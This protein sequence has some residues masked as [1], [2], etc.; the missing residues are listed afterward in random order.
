MIDRPGKHTRQTSKQ[1][2]GK[3]ITFKLQT[4]SQYNIS[5]FSNKMYENEYLPVKQRTLRTP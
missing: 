1:L 5:L 4:Y 3:M 2:I